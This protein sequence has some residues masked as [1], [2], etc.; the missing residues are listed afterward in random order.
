MEITIDKP[1][2]TTYY[3]NGEVTL[4]MKYLY[5]LT[6]TVNFTGTA[7]EVEAHP[8]SSETNWGN[9]NEIKKQFIEDIIIKHYETHGAE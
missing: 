4:D 5:T 8:S 3:F 7:Y 1:H 9:W 2:Q 6:K